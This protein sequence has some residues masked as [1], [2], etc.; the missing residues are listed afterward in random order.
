[1]TRNN[2]YSRWYRIKLNKRKSITFW[3]NYGDYISDGDYISVYDAKGRR[4]DVEHAGTQSTKYFTQ[5][6]KK[7]I[8][9]IRIRPEKYYYWDRYYHV[10]TLKWK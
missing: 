9:Y 2:Y 5:K 3:S 8:Y 6:Q 1:M 10:I 4:I 7:G